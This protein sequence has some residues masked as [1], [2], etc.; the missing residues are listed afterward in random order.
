M[1]WIAFLV[2]HVAVAILGFLLPNG[3]MG[4]VTN[5]YDPWSRAALNGT[6]IV[7]I[8]EA[9]V[10]PQ[11]AL[12]PLVL[13]QLF[14]FI[15]GY[16]VAWAILVTICDAV[17]FAMLLG[18][19]RSAGRSV[20]AW[21]L[22]AFIVL[23]GPVQMYRLD[24]VTVPLAIAGSL[25]LVGRPLLGSVLLSVATWIK[26]WPAALIAAA[27]IAVRRRLAVLGG[28]LLV[29]GATLAVVVAA[30]GAPHAFGFV[31]DQAD[32]GLQVEAPVSSFYLWGVVLGLRG[33]SIDYS[34]ELL[35]FE[36]TG[37]NV[38]AVI[39]VMTPVLVV[40]VLAVAALGAFRAW[41]GASFVRLFPPLSLG[42]VLAFIVFNKVGSPQYVTWIIAPLTVALVIDRHRWWGPAGLGL[43][44]ALLTQLV[45]PITYYAMLDGAPVPSAFLTIRNILLIVLLGWV[46]ARLVRVPG[47]VRT[48][49]SSSVG[50]VVPASS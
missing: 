30:G 44:I 48:F 35:T 34:R 43:A 38:D 46:I 29:S 11:L 13:A 41:R 39:A 17:V 42:L 14:T 49:A 47:R 18:R 5:V 37:P 20:A 27:M 15:A 12:I 50:D 40:A 32:R 6:T 23:L 31:A 36:V 24:A 8:T 28:A 16:E 22:L 2:A 1:L 26:V 19:G 7:G 4:D 10:Y 3:P 45:Y 9:W 25:W 33:W 21:Y